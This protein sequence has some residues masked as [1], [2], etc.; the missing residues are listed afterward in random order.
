MMGSVYL[1]VTGHHCFEVFPQ[2]TWNFWKFKYSMQSVSKYNIIE[3]AYI[4]LGNGFTFQPLNK[5]LNKVTATF[6]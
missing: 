5:K 6:M 1:P 2:F 3:A 4:K